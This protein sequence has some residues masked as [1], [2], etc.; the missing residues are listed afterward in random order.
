MRRE[1]GNDA[2]A[3]VHR[4]DRL[5]AGVL[6]FTRRPAVRAAYQELFAARRVYKE[7]RA[8]SDATA[9]EDLRDGIRVA[10]R[11]EKRAGDL[12][13][14]VV[15]GPVNAIST[16]TRTDDGFRLVPETGRTHQLRMH[17]AGLGHPSS[18]IRCTRTCVRNWPNCPITAISLGHCSWWRQPCGSPTQSRAPTAASSPDD[19]ERYPRQRD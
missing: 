6:V 8:H 13:A 2:L 3:P 11:I 18:T 9:D 12:R 15:D 1:L 7:Y 10:N 5:T 19:G 17:M 16:I 4:L 14:H